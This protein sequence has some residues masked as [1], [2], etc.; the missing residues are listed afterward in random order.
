[1]SEHKN[2]KN[3]T[4]EKTFGIKEVSMRKMIRALWKK[5]GAEIVFSGLLD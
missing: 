5:V 2:I 4:T 1:M 3:T